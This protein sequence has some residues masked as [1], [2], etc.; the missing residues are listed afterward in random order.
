[1]TQED[2]EL[3]L[4]D[5]CGRLPY[6]VRMLEIEPTNNIKLE[7]YLSS[8]TSQGTCCVSTN[9]GGIMC[10]SIDAFKPYLFPMS[11]MTKEQLAELRMEHEKDLKNMAIC[12]KKCS[13]GDNSLRGKNISY[14]GVDW[15]N[16]NHF[17]YHGL[18]EKGLAIDATNLN[19]Y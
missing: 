7:L 4:Q 6:N 18:I 12:M 5:L 14:N 15:C 13:E 10:S 19:I 8:I 9:D 2:K 16:R 17:D 3:L 1:M 11:S